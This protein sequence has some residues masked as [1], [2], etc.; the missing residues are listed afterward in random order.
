M[1]LLQL[2]ETTIQSDI[3]SHAA[4]FLTVPQ[5]SLPAEPNRS[6]DDI[7]EDLDL[8]KIVEVSPANLAHALALLLSPSATNE[9]ESQL[10][11]VAKG[12]VLPDQSSAATAADIRFAELIAY[13]E[14]VP[15]ENSPLSGQA[16]SKFVMT[17]SG[18]AL[19]AY[20]GFV[21]F[22]ASPLLLIVVPAGMILCGAAKGV[23]DGLEQ[24]LRERILRSFKTKPN[25]RGKSAA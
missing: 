7:V 25:K 14:V 17:A 8:R 6:L 1:K 3:S 24:G 20:A 15:F 12:Q 22:G 2:Y 19:G 21:A 5:R 18:G 23:A 16:L 10:I 4:Q 11:S 9:L 13:S